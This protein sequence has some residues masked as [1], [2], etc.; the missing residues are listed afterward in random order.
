MCLT[1]EP[2][3]FCFCFL[4][5]S[6]HIF[7][8]WNDS[9]RRHRTIAVLYVE[10]L[11]HCKSHKTTLNFH[12]SYIYVPFLMCQYWR[13]YFLWKPFSKYIPLLCCC[14]CSCKKK[15]WPVNN[16]S[17]RLRL[18]HTHFTYPKF[19]GLLKSTTC[20]V[21]QQIYHTSH[22]RHCSWQCMCCPLS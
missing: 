19:R 15:Y 1:F 18:R 8:E 3:S 17:S 14:Y 11:K 22:H 12:Y 6:S 4:I 20:A 10:E 2:V 5:T 21:T 13:V 7:G 16:F 9:V